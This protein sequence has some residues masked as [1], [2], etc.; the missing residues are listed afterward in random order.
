[1]TMRVEIGNT[2]IVWEENNGC[3]WPAV[4]LFIAAHKDLPDKAPGVAD[5]FR[6]WKLDTATIDEVLAYMADTGGEP[7]DAAVWF[8]KNRE[9]IWTG[10]VPDDIAS[11]VKVAVAG[12]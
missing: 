7:V 11:K 4:D 1:M 2:L 8:L 5:M 9:A 3:A 10:F 6:N 12:M